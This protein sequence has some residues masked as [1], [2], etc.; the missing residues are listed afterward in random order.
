MREEKVTLVIDEG[1]KMDIFQKQN[2]NNSHY[3]MLGQSLRTRLA[4]LVMAEFCT[5]GRYRCP[6]DRWA[7]CAAVCLMVNPIYLPE[8]DMVSNNKPNSGPIAAQN[9]SNPTSQP[10][11]FLSPPCATTPIVGI[12]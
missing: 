12:S 11:I 2:Q 1:R 8:D 10:H 9:T 3:N 6:M 4:H 5:V 7:A